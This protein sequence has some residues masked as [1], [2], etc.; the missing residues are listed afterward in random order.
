[1]RY[2]LM[3]QVPQP[4]PDLVAHDRAPDDAADDETDLWQRI[5][6]ILPEQVDHHMRP[7]GAATAP[8]GQREVSTP[9]HPVPGRQHDERRSDLGGQTE[10]RAR[11]LRR[12]ADKIARPA[13]VRMRSRKPCFLWRRRLFG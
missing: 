5:D 9:P 7:A 10:T 6:V 11:P 12:R 1:L 2:V 3:R 4:A 8:D 13:R